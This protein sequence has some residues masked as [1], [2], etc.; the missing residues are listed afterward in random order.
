M[1]ARSKRAS[2]ALEVYFRPRA[3]ADLIGLYEY[4][5]ER[6]GPGI[7]GGYI[8]PIEAACTALAMSPNRGTRRDDLSRGLRTII[9]DDAN[10][11]SHSA[12]TAFVTAALLMARSGHRMHLLCPDVPLAGAA[13]AALAG[14][15]CHRVDARRQQ[16]PAGHRFQR[17]AATGRDR[18]RNCFGRRGDQCNCARSASIDSLNR[19]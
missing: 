3:E 17:R 7:A 16:S 2:V 10:I 6:S 13:T 15:A 14:A 19:G 12:Q 18:S 11:G 1:R 9:A 8:E 4:I 5:A